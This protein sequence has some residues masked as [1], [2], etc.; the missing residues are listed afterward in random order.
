M[1]WIDDFIKLYSSKE[2]GDFT[3]ALEL[4]RAHIP[5]KLY[6]YRTTNNLE[7]LKEEICDGEI[8]LIFTFRNERPF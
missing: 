7:Y 4:K 1:D 2:K 5:N 8:F 6:R 3:N